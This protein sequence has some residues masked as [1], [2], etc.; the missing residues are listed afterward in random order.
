MF[1]SLFTAVVLT[2]ASS[3][4]ASPNN[5]ARNPAVGRTCGVNPSKEYIA[6]AEAH[7]AKYKVT[8]SS[9]RGATKS[10]D[11]YFHVIYK[12][13]SCVSLHFL[14]YKHDLSLNYFISIYP[15]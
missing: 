11:V 14:I 1:R 9:D 13:T 10:I 7:F 3:A 5:P 8:P 4:L 2:L 12:D 6:T 15:V